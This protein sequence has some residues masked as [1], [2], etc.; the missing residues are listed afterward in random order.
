MKTD[1]TISVG[2]KVYLV[3]ICLS[4]LFL[5]IC[6]FA[7]Q[8]AIRSVCNEFRRQH[9][10]YDDPVIAEMKRRIREKETMYKLGRLID[11]EISCDPV[12]T[13]ALKH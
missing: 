5:C 13:Y 12:E 1:I 8:L 4:V 3:L 6:Y 2:W 9:D 11:Q 10:L 7:P